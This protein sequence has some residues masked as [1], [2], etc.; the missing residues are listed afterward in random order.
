MGHAGNVPAY[1][2]LANLT[3]TGEAAEN[4]ENNALLT[5]AQNGWVSIPLAASEEITTAFT[6]R[7]TTTQTTRAILQTALSQSDLFKIEKSSGNFLARKHFI[8]LTPNLEVWITDDF[9]ENFSGVFENTSWSF[10][11][12][13]PFLQQLIANS[14]LTIDLTIEKGSN[15][16]EAYAADFDINTSSLGRDFP[17]NGSVK[18]E[19]EKTNSEI[20]TIQTITPPT[21]FTIFDIATYLNE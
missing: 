18:L 7:K 9:L 4:W 21:E 1:L 11:E 17:F 19:I 10:A 14:N 6:A 2:K 5:Q 13:K 16:L 20:D 15:L 12:I 8:T 3:L